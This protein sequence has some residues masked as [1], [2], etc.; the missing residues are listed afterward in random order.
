ML[1]VLAV[2]VA[3]RCER[4]GGRAGTVSAV[5]RRGSLCA[6]WKASVTMGRASPCKAKEGWQEE[7]HSVCNARIRQGMH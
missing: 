2:R 3:G 5:H 4:A 7:E 6:L 1:L